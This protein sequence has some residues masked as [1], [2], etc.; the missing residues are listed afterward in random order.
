MR[1]NF[2]KKV[3]ALIFLIVLCSSL[4]QKFMYI[5]RSW[6]YRYVY[7]YELLC[8]VLTVACALCHVYAIFKDKRSMEIHSF[9][10]TILSFVFT[11]VFILSTYI[12]AGDFSVKWV[13]LAE[14][15]DGFY[16]YFSSSIVLLA[17]FMCALPYIKKE[18]N[19]KIIVEPVDI[20]N[21]YVLCYYKKGLDKIFDDPRGNFAV[22]VIP[23]KAEKVEFCVH[24]DKAQRVKIL[25]ENLISIEVSQVK[26][27]LP[28]ELTEYDKISIEAFLFSRLGAFIASDDLLKNIENYGKKRALSSFKIELKYYENSKEKVAVFL[29]KDDPTRVFTDI[30]CEVRSHEEG[31]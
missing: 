1:L 8:V 11:G 14:L 6:H 30:L 5:N 2:L 22:I 4:P 13:H 17:E 25:K 20:Q 19:E 31:K 15:N 12:S 23:D 21:Q 26:E 29:S 27:T 18:P 7:S 24:A 28:T 16:W 10:F 9:I 3:I